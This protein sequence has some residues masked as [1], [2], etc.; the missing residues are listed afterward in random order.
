MAGVLRG[1]LG[2]PLRLVR[3]PVGFIVLLVGAHRRRTFGLPVSA[4]RQQPV[5][6]AVR[7]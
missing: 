4:G 3:A 1:V 5:L 7:V 2:F 6:R